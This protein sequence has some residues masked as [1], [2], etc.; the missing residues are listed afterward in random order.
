M[1]HI[2]LMDSDFYFSMD[3]LHES[4]YLQSNRSE[5]Y[6]RY[7]RRLL[8]LGLVYPC[9]HSRKDVA[10]ALSAPHEGDSEIVFPPELRPPFM[11]DD[12]VLKN[13][14][15]QERYPSDLLALEK[16]SATSKACNWRFRVPDGVT[17]Q[18]VDKCV[19]LKEYVAGRDFGDF[20]VY[21]ADSIPSYD[22]ACV[23]DD[24]E[25]GITEVFHVQL[26]VLEM[27]SYHRFRSFAERICCSARLARFSSMRPC[28]SL[29][30]LSITLPSFGTI[31]DDD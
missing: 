22:F 11:Q 16:P 1:I 9:S 29:R 23:I 2:F 30:R 10:R 20:I 26:H 21:R 28:P 19:G 13:I 25:M 6:I 12:S 18:F 8:S 14:P 31:S 15:V 4:S 24:A 5:L 7:W 17:I 3:R 27:L